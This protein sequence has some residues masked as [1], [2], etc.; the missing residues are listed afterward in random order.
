MRDFGVE[1]EHAP[2]FENLSHRPLTCCSEEARSSPLLR[3]FLLCLS[4]PN[5][6]PGGDAAEYTALP[7][8][9]LFRILYS[10]L[11]SPPAR[12]CI[13]HLAVSFSS[14]PVLKMATASEPREPYATQDASIKWRQS[15][16]ILSTLS[17][18][19][20]KSSFNRFNEALRLNDL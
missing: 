11:S 18:E 13:N 6:S 19:L 20:F 9:L 2:R 14:V 4:N 8:L 3:R 16:E 7:S 17:W 12:C 10:P 15:S 5:P 1:D